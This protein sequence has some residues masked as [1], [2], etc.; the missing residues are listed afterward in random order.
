MNKS[1]VKKAVPKKQRGRP[2]K[3]DESSHPITITLPDR[4]LRFVDAMGPDRARALVRAVD[5]LQA[6][7]P[8]DGPLVKVVEVA[9]EVGIIVVAPS[10]TLR[11]I[12]GLRLVE[13]APARY[14]LT[15]LHGFS[16]ADLEIA[17]SDIL[18]LDAPVH[19]REREL[20]VQLL[21]HLRHLRKADRMTRAE[22]LYVAL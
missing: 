18:R 17:L 12:H 5:H 21:D 13:V 19:E 8:H 11:K 9:S 3:F 4:V 20:L 15:L 2:R 16:P 22:M 14:L 10:A 1:R 7:T 6:S